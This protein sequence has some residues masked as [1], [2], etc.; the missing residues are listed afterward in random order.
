MAISAEQLN[1]ILAAK[2]REFAKAMDRNA[3]RVQKFESDAKKNLSGVSQGFDFL[4]AAASRLG[5][6]L[7]AGA[8]ATGM[9]QAIKSAIDVGAQISNLARIAGTG[10]TEFQKFAIAAQTVGIDQSKLADILKDVNDKFGDY[11]ST[12][13]GPLADF[14]DNIAPKVGLTK[15]AFMGLSSDQALGKYVKALQ[16]AGVNQQEMT[17]Y[18]E[19]LASDATV[20][21]PLLADNARVLTSIG[22]SAE[23]T[24]RILDESMIAN[25]KA[26]ETRWTEVLGVMT[27]HWNNFWLT[28][29]M[30]IDEL[31]DISTE[32][33]LGTAMQEV[34]RQIGALQQAQKDFEPFTDPQYRQD[35]ADSYGTEELQRAQ[36]EAQA[37]LDATTASYEAAVKAANDLKTAMD[38]DVTNLPPIVVND[39][40]SD[41]GT[42]PSAGAGQTDPKQKAKEAYDSLMGSIDSTKRATNEFGAA[43]KVVNDA[44]AQ[45]VITQAQA[46][47]TLAILADRLKTAT[48]EMID[49]SSVASILESGMTSAF[50]SILDGTQSAKDAFRAMAAD[51]IK[52]LYRVLIVQRMVGAIGTATKAGS[53]ILGAIGNAFPALK[54]SASGG[55]QYAGQPTVVGEHGRELFVPSSAGRILSVPQAK[56]AVSGGDGVTIVQNISISTGVQQTVRNEIKSMMPQIADSAK[57]AVLDARRRGGSYGSAFS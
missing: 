50:M 12:G 39:P 56:A 34:D 42:T 6:T 49:L 36:A 46:D 51:I 21:N 2:D 30:G 5:L 15:E 9:I 18:M 23:K 4:G 57:A 47:T 40:G 11:M 16:D 8:L 7:S 17:F 43:Q 10:T 32:A 31:F 3:R 38:T 53:G 28:V 26:M 54:A 25:A 27:T 41:T 37:A 44:L 29:A 20:L 55:A 19:A 45:G 48:G 35:Y 52:E 22:D 14:F 1:I 24:G 33:Q 13:A